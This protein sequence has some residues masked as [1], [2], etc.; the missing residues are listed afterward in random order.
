MFL[1]ILKYNIFYQFVLIKVIDKNFYR[2]K[3]KINIKAFVILY[4]EEIYFKMIII[5]KY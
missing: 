2:L 1:Y 5:N 3:K 4:Q